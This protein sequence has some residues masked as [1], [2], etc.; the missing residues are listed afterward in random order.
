MAAEAVGPLQP[1]EK[2]YPQERDEHP[3]ALK[4]SGPL[5]PQTTSY[6]CT[7]ERNEP[8]KE[9]NQPAG[10]DLESKKS[11]QDQRTASQPSPAHPD[12]G[13][14]VVAIDVTGTPLV[15]KD[16]GNLARDNFQDQMKRELAYREEMVQQLQIVRDT[17]CNELD[18][19]RKA[20]YAIQ[21]KLKAQLLKRCRTFRRT[22][23]RPG[24]CCSGQV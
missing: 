21:Q 24:I 8:D 5:G 6:L 23:G 18:Q 20:R 19:E 2:V 3:Q 11:Y 10:E 12:R 14:E 22:L 4:P 1:H 9:D 16:F 15:E 7:P 13:E 17:L